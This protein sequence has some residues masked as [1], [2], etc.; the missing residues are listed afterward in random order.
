MYSEDKFFVTHTTS[1]SNLDY[2]LKIGSIQPL[3]LQKKIFEEQNPEEKFS[4]DLH[5]DYYTQSKDTEKYVNS[6]FYGFL[7]PN[8]DGEIHYDP[9]LLGSS[10]HFVFSSK[11]IKNSLI[12]KPEFF[13]KFK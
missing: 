3:S 13:N 4:Y 6:V 12:G 1:I 9:M 5:S 2:I 7:C 8:K 10:V 11:I